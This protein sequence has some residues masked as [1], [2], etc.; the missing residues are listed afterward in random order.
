MSQSTLNLYRNIIRSA[1]VFPS[2]NR[3]RIV[4]EIRVDFRKNKDLQEGEPL[5]IA[6][7]VAIKGLEQLN[8]YTHLDPRKGS[9]W[10]VS[11]DTSPMPKRPSDE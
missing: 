5:R 8:A 7:G 9:E 10:A 6:M 1:K 2:R 11:M 4:E 3:T